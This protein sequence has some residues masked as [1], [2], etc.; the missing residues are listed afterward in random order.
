MDWT[1]ILIEG[2]CATALMVLILKGIDYLQNRG[3]TESNELKDIVKLLVQQQRE[4]AELQSR[5]ESDHN[6]TVIDMSTIMGSAVKEAAEINAKAINGMSEA[7]AALR[8]QCAVAQ[9][10]KRSKK[11]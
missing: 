5:C 7:I 1:R 2:G 11:D 3:K 9:T 8:T 10:P 4:Q 6:K